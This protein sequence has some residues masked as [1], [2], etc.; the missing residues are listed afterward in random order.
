[1]TKTSIIPEQITWRGRVKRAWFRR[2]GYTYRDPR[3]LEQTQ[4]PPAKWHAG[5]DIIQTKTPH[6]G[7]PDNPTFDKVQMH[8]R[9]LCGYVYTFD[10]I[11][12]ATH[13]G[14]A[15]YRDEVKSDHLRCLKCDQ[16]LAK[17]EKNR[18]VNTWKVPATKFDEKLDVSGEEEIWWPSSQ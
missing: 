11:L 13:Y 18:R 2:D 8:V 16:E 4:S 3:T 15:T 9:A 1:M 5:V 14:R 10:F 7:Y 12:A 17:D 6:P